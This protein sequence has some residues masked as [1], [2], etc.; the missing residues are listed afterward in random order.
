MPAESI[1][2]EKVFLAKPLR[3]KVI[4]LSLNFSLAS[5]AALRDNILGAAIN[6]DYRNI[7]QPKSYALLPEKENPW[8]FKRPFATAAVFGNF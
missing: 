1:L 7:E 8:N 6:L 4:S 2:K 5:L 3:R